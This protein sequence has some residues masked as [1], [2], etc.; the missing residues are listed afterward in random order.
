MN[1][2]SI[3]YNFVPTKET[4]NITTRNVSWPQNIHKM[5]SRP[6]LHPRPRWESSQI[7]SWIMGGEGKRGEG[8][9]GEEKGGKGKEGRERKN[10]QTKS[11][12][13]ALGH[14]MH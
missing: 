13:T 6:G 3:Y 9:G 2:Y 14:D 10:V 5:R 4:K 8:E 1:F 7:P 12:S 11:L